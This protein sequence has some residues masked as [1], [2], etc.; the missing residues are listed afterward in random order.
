MLPPRPAFPG[1]DCENDQPVASA[2]KAAHFRALLVQCRPCAARPFPPPRLAWLF[3]LTH[4]TPIK[5][6]GSKEDNMTVGELALLI[7]SIAQLIASCVATV[8]AKR[9]KR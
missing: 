7:S 3:G 5:A 2:F 4:V 8:S 6:D 1:G 9:R